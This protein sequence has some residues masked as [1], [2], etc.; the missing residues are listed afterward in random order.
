VHPRDAQGQIAAWSNVVDPLKGAAEIK[1]TVAG[2]VDTG[3]ALATAKSGPQLY[4]ANFAQG[5]ADV[6][7][8]TFTQLTLPANGFCDRRLPKGYA[9]FGV[10]TTQSSIFV[11]YA[12]V[13]PATHRN[14]SVW[15]SASSMNSL[16]TRAAAAARRGTRSMLRSSRRD[17]YAPHVAPGAPNRTSTRRPAYVGSTSGRPAPLCG[18]SQRPTVN[19]DFR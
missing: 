16:R 4:A 6:C 13:D 12:K 2:A 1:A 17:T 18:R 8:S 10:R 11:A 15:V 14:G 3:L 5:T 7:D 19:A 9:P